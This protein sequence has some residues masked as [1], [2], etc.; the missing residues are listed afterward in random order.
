MNILKKDLLSYAKAELSSFSLNLDEK[1]A[2]SF[3]QKDILEEFKELNDEEVKAARHRH[4]NIN[5]TSVESYAEKELDLGLGR[6]VIYGIRHLSG[7][8]NSPF[9][10]IRPNF[11]VGSKE[12]ALNIY[13]KI[14]DELDVFDP[15]SLSFW[16]AKKVNVDFYGSVYMVAL[17]EK[18]KNKAPWI[19]EEK[20]ELEEVEN[21]S[22]F[23]WYEREYLEFNKAKPALAKWVRH[24]SLQTMEASRKEGLLQYV[25]IEGQIAGLVAAEKGSLLGHSG[26]YFNEVFLRKKWKGKG[27]A[28]SV[29]R[30][31][32][33]E[34]CLG[35]EF[36]WGT[37]Y[38]DNLPSYRTAFSNLRRPVRYECFVHLK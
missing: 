3:L 15:L 22:Y 25:K 5:G 4:F 36:V 29:Q 18:I 26:T 32:I 17:A 31:F 38:F 24:N 2:L 7:E 1:K 8:A 33:A 6:R 28:K 30:K 34:Q 20:I 19:G 13:Q 9:V 16:S 10:S 21:T 12:E 37:I 11:S 23:D 14:K 35:D 27:L